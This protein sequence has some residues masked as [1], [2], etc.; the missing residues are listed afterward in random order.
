MELRDS[1][2][3]LRL[4]PERKGDGRFRKGSTPWNKGLTWQQ[5]GIS[6]EERSRR[7][8]ILRETNHKNGYS[9]KPTR[10]RPV[11]QMDEYGNRVH[12]YVS[13]EAAARKMGCAGRNIRKVCDGQRKHAMGYC[14]KW[15]ERF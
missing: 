10:C 6:S 7:L 4:Q 15:D 5:M 1:A 11:I 3:V 14:W 9:H 13:S 2:Y 12:W 8:A